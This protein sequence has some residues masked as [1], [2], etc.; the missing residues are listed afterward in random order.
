MKHF[1]RPF[2]ALVLALSP[3]IVRA[4]APDPALDVLKRQLQELQQQLQQLQQQTLSLQQKIEQWETAK[5]A[6]PPQ[7]TMI[8]EQVTQLNAKVD[9][10]VEAQ[11]KVRPG[12]LNPAIG[13]VGETLFSRRS[14]SSAATGSDRPGGF[15]VFQRSMELI[16]SA[17]ADP[18]AK[19]YAVVNA[20]AD[21]VTGE[22]SASIEEVALKTTSLPWNLEVTAGR[23]FAE[24]GRLSY[25]HDHELPFVNRPLAIDR[26]VGGE[27]KTDG[28]Q[29]NWL[30][31][32]NHY[33]SLTLGLGDQFG[34]DPNN[35]GPFR[36]F[37]EL[38]FWG[39]LSTSFDLTPDWQLDTGV[40]GLLNPR[41]DDLAGVLVQPDGSTLT[42]HKRRLGGFDLRLTYAPLRNNQFRSFTW[43]TEILVSD[44]GY[45]FDPNGSLD[46]DNALPFLDGDEF[47]GS[48]GSLALYSY[49]VYKMNRRWSVGFLFDWAE[50]PLNKHDRASA[51]SPFLTLALSH[52]NQ[53]RLQ[54]TH[55]AH[56]AVSGLRD[57]DALSL[58]W[59]WII[60]SHAHG[61]QQR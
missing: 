14:G 16:F 42:E 59:A 32:M 1:C 4:Q 44:N 54:Y 2:L 33:L 10:V 30:A 57:D 35:P 22:A 28:L 46:P 38:N 34:D 51:Y 47:S 36:A 20:E 41:T 25:I 19:G 37:R 55:T 15:D 12:E 18:F 39:R 61:W 11:K 49:V 3:G 27:S 56:N 40:S 48:V 13:L 24:F 17:S 29:V 50:S 9:R 58:Q 52:W 26:Y 7:E 31:P 45:L 21:P 60:G 8:Q 5:P 6:A 43:G 53:L 23:F